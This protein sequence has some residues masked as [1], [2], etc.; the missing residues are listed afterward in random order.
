[1]KKQL[2]SLFFV[3]LLLTQ[4][5]PLRQIG[6]VLSSNQL[7]EELP[8][9]IDLNKTCFKKSAQFSEYLSAV[10]AAAV[11]TY[12][13]YT[14]FAPSFADRIPQY[15]AGEILVPPPNC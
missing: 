15:P 9:S 7:N 6:S 13:D 10:P 5:L 3:F 12:I 11:S 1:M 14:F 4:M 2:F 8:H